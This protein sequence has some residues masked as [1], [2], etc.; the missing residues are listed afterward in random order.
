MDSPQQTLIYNL[1][2]HSIN[3]ALIICQIPFKVLFLL[4]LK[5]QILHYYIVINQ[6]ICSTMNINDH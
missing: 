1:F 4:A 6:S 5:E 2:I 3:I